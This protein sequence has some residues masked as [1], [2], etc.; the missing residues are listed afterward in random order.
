MLAECLS[1]TLDYRC[2]DRDMLVRKAATKRV[3][4]SDLRAA[5]EEPPVVPGRFSH[6]RYV[7]LALIQ[8]ALMEEVRS[9]KAVYHGP[10]GQ[11]L[12]KGVPGLLRLRIIAP[13]ELRICMAQERL[14]LNRDEA[15]AHIGDIDWDRRNWT[16]FLYG[17]DW[18]DPA[19]FDLVINLEHIGFE[20][21]CRVVVAAIGQSGFEFSAEER[22]A[23]NDLAIAS[24]VRAELALNSFT[25]NLEVDVEAT[26]GKVLIRGCL[27]EELEQVERVAVAISGVTGLTVEDLGLPA[28]D[29]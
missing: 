29:A 8:A 25:S 16:R 24:R 28:V 15:I 20:Q 23:M 12:L 13:M 7:Y 4:E 5:L 18:G 26:G 6:R 1:R 14:K 27:F 17:V 22:A 9:G 2:I 19:L 11:L 10:A 21:A 3:S